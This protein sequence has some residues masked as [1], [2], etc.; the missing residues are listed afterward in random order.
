[1]PSLSLLAA[2]PPLL[3]AALSAA[4]PPPLP[5]AALPLAPLE[6]TLTAAQDSAPPG[7]EPE[8][9]A[10]QDADDSEQGNEIIIEGSYGPP[11][12]DPVE[13]INAESY[14][15]TQAVDQAFV[16]PLAYA[17][18]DGLPGP[19][20]DGLGNVVKNLGEPSNA[21]NFL[22]QGKVGKAF[23]TVGR[24]A[25]NSTL[26][27][28]GLIDVA[29]K[30]GIG[31]P[32]RRNGFANT[33]GFYGIGPGPYLYLPVTGATS[34][35]DVIGST[36]DQL[37]LPVTVGKP[38][39]TYE[40][41]GTYFVVNGLDARLEVDAELAEIR[42]SDDPYGMRRDTYLERR[43]REI[44]ALKGE[45]LPEPEAETAPPSENPPPQSGLSLPERLQLTAVA[46]PGGR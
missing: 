24:L 25:I 15:I 20:R 41:A 36:L 19:L 1:M 8:P 14:R 46:A 26:G 38:F 22:L 33:A 12:T 10:G 43:K 40:F 44:A 21:L 13:R 4:G 32:Y 16:E 3:S 29:G 2:S 37:L 5:A 28:G 18:R 45:T 30:P 6:W 31:L 9:E 39:N 34:V 27:L 11:A 7:A 35:R 23:E 17:Y 42:E